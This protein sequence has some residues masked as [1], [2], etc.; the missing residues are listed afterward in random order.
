M[1]WE[2]K[3]GRGV[4]GWSPVP[5]PGLG[6][7]SGCLLL[8]GRDEAWAWGASYTAHYHSPEGCEYF[9]VISAAFRALIMSQLR[10]K[11]FTHMTS[12]LTRMLWSRVMMPIFQMRKL[13]PREVKSLALG[14]CSQKVAGP[15]FKA[16]QSG[17][18]TC[19]VHTASVV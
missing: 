7:P 17:P 6:V 12:M 11:R 15:G 3:G 1:E 16:R 18:G 13:R 8:T 5:G 10:S 14:L 2:V 9:I 4:S 19:A